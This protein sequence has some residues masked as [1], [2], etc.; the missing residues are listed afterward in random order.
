MAAEPLRQWLQVQKAAIHPCIEAKVMPDMG[1]GVGIAATEALKPGTVL[2]RVPPH[3]L[4]TTQKGRADPGFRHLCSDKRLAPLQ[5]LPFYL[6]FV[7]SDPSSFWHPWAANLPAAYGTLLECDEDTLAALRKCPRRLRKVV[8]ERERARSLHREAVQIFRETP[9]PEAV[10]PATAALLRRVVV[11]LPFEEFVGLY[12]AV[13]SR[14]FY[15]AV[16]P[17][18]HDVWAMIPWLDYFNYTD[19]AGHTAAFNPAAQKFEITT[20]TPVEPGQQVLLHYGTYSNFELLLWYG[21]VLP[22][23]KNL[24][25]KLSPMADANGEC[26]A[27][28][29]WLQQLLGA[30][31]FDGAQQQQQQW[32]SASAVARW[33]DA[34]P[35]LLQQRGLAAQWGVSPCP[36]YLSGAEMSAQQPPRLTSA[37][38]E[39]VCVVAGLAC[40]DGASKATVAA[41][42]VLALL[43]A[44]LA[45][46]DPDAPKGGPA[47]G[48]DTARNLAGVVQEE[49][50]LLSALVALPVE[51]FEASLKLHGELAQ[52]DPDAPKGE[53]AA[54][55]DTARNL[56]QEEFCLLSALVALPPEA[57][58]ASLKLHGVL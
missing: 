7:R 55:S 47:A 57:F 30:V 31:S 53:P 11:D 4:F 56:A 29:G 28:A 18:R 22:T 3:L 44:E 40:P 54:A 49:F 6:S 33:A 2:A 17:A 38:A 48:S 19:E 58:E 36:G 35:R 26:P 52:W 21:F 23:N 16:N 42:I 13:M 8:A 43:R 51:A 41:L 46:W 37:M 34:A 24:E 9:V 45:Q 32:A 25:Y 1:G 27:D 20:K 50:C 15:Y 14:G 39:G 5:I 10:S 12:C